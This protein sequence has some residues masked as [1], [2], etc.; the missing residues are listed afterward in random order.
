MYA[1]T[2]HLI[3]LRFKT[4]KE[5]MGEAVLNEAGIAM[6][7][8]GDPVIIGGVES[9]SLAVTFSDKIPLHVHREDDELAVPQ[10]DVL[11]TYGL[12]ELDEEGEMVRQENDAVRFRLTENGR[13]YVPGQPRA[14][15]AGEG[16]EY[17]NPRLVI[18]KQSWLKWLSSSLWVISPEIKLL[19]RLRNRPPVPRLP[20]IVNRCRLKTVCKDLLLT[21]AKLPGS[22]HAGLPK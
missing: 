9:A 1:I 2:K 4:Y 22:N 14:V 8:V 10:T 7:Y 18:R 15:R 19:V 12:P 6:A 11:A 20:S 17:L 16:H 3:S 5:A 13:L 21:L